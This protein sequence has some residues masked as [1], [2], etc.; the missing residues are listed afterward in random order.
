MVITRSSDAPRTFQ[1]EG[2]FTLDPTESRVLLSFQGTL[3]IENLSKEQKVDYTIS[4]Q[5]TNEVIG[6]DTIDFQPGQNT[7]IVE[8]KNVVPRLKV[9]N[10]STNLAKLKVEVG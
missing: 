9:E 4:N 6:K 2:S 5:Q 10:S 1:T 8:I 3:E 7:K